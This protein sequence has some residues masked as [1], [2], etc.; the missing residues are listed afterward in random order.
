MLSRFRRPAAD[1]RVELS[2]T[3]LQPGDEL[4]VRVSLIPKDGFQVRRGSLEIVCTESFVEYVSTMRAGRHGA[5]YSTQR[6]KATRILS[7]YEKVFM[8]GTAECAE[9]CPIMSILIGRAARCAAY[10]KRRNYA[11]H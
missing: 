5:H 2:E 1:F 7:R 4:N 8:D 6:L 3:T 10:S 9:V 11:L